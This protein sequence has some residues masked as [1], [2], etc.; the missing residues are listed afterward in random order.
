MKRQ[1]FGQ[2]CRESTKHSLTT[3]TVQIESKTEAEQTG[4]E[5]QRRTQE[6]CTSLCDPA[7]C[8]EQEQE[9]LLAGI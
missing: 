4:M 9:M 5:T 7:A 3:I 1:I 6:P 8:A 2:T